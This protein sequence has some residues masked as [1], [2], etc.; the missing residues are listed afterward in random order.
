VLL[1]SYLRCLQN[2]E[3][4]LLCLLLLLDYVVMVRQWIVCLFPLVCSLLLLAIGEM[5]SSRS[6]CHLCRKVWWLHLAN[7]CN[8]GVPLKWILCSALFE[9]GGSCRLNDRAL[10]W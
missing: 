9:A 5:A 8:V 7:L 6:W 10:G 4:Y 3:L 2:V 1:M